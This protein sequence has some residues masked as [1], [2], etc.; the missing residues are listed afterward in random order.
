MAWRDRI[1]TARKALVGKKVRYKDE[2]YNIVDVDYNGMVLID[3]PA[4]FTDTTAMFDI[5]T[6]NSALVDTEELAEKAST[7]LKIT[8]KLPK[9]FRKHYNSD[10]FKDSL[11]RVIFDLVQC[12]KHDS[13][14]DALSG[15]YEI[16]VVEALRDAFIDSTA[17]P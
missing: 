16:E 10:K 9:E 11:E 5:W 4:K 14:Y 7:G 8:L 6:V 13:A 3:K 15:N 2:V 1:E 12:N 17:S